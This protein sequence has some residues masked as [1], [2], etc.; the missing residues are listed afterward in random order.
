MKIWKKEDAIEVLNSLILEIPEVKDSN[1]NSK[2]HMRWLANSQRIIGEIFGLNSRY[3]NTLINFSWRHNGQ[4]IFQSYDIEDAIAYRNNEA[5]LEQMDQVEG[6]FLAAKDHL[7]Q[8]EINDVYEGEN[9]APEASDLIKIINIGEKKL[10]KTIREIPE[11][12]IEIQHKYEDLLIG[13]DIKYSREFP[14]IEYSSKQ[15]IP[16]F[17]FEKISLAV[18]IKLCKRDEKSMI[19]QLNDDILAY[20]TKFRNILF[21][22]YDLGQ[23]RDIETFKGSFESDNDIIIQIIKH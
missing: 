22:I 9:T 4:M 20:K 11:R 17:S 6:I 1:R 7:T 19:A 21:V 8:S 23:I 5:F 3:Y 15:Y 18:E 14:H 12:E 16:D 13:N 10:R 2:E